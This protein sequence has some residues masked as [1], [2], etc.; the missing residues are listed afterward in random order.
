MLQQTQVDRVIP[1]YERFL[2][3]FPTARELANAST[4]EVIRFWS[5][6]GYNRRAVNL[7]RAARAV[8]ES[9]GGEFPRS[10]AALQQLPGVG[11]YTAG[12]IAAFAF[13]HDVAFLD[14]NMRRVVSRV[15]FGEEPGTDTPD[16][17]L[18]AA[19]ETLVPLA[20]GG[21]GIRH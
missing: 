1:Y 21:P 8:T 5:G 12:A 19:A 7:Q 17:T 15:V 18:M 9:L 4:A 11:A 6:L 3:R 2:Q 20:R 10:L 14:T 16:A 13:E